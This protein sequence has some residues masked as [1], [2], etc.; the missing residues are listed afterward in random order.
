[1]EIIKYK[2]ID[3]SSFELCSIQGTQ[4][5]VFINGDRCYKLVTTLYSSER[6]KLEA[7]FK[8]MDGISIDNVLLPKELIM[9]DD[10][11]MGYTM[12]YFVDSF[13]MFDRF[14]R[15]KTIDVNEIF[16]ATKEVSKILREVHDKGIILQDFSFENVLINGQGDIRISDIDGC[17]YNGINSPF[18]SSIMSQ[19]YKFMRKN[20]KVTENLD[21]QSLFFSMLCS[22]YDMLVFG[23]EQYD[24][25]SDKIPTIGKLR[26]LFVKLM[27]STETEI[28]YLD[29][30]LG[31]DHYIIDR[32]EQKKLRK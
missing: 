26:E 9:D 10:M 17:T 5:K 24:L 16:K 6:K 4:S 1:M 28:P 13:N 19:Y 12:D 32:E 27:S 11:L 23:G 29:E 30:V 25:Y 22:I 31:E 7:K 21:R 18:I 2:D 15:V 8:A 20:P 3:I 14:V